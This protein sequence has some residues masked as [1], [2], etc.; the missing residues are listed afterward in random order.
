[1]VSN[2]SGLMEAVRDG[3][4]GLVVPEDDPHAAAEALLSLLSDPGK[5]VRMGQAA[6]SRALR[7][8]TWEIC[9]Q[10]FDHLLREM[11][12]PVEELTGFEKA[13]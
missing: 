7:E 11:I 13:R 1:V 8:Q 2:N 3:E 12:E 5:I 10:Q 4:T 6:R 9:M